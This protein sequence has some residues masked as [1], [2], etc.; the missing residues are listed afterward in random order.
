MGTVRCPLRLSGKH[1]PRG[2]ALELSRRRS[3]SG[4]AS[5]VVR[6]VVCPCH[7]VRRAQ[8]PSRQHQRRGMD[9]QQLGRRVAHHRDALWLAYAA[10]PAPSPPRFRDGLPLSEGQ[11]RGWQAA[12]PRR[13]RRLVGTVLRRRQAPPFAALRLHPRRSACGGRRHRARTRRVRARSRSPGGGADPG[14]DAGGDGDG[15]CHP[16]E[17][18]PAHAGFARAVPEQRR[19]A[20]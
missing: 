20:A 8:A 15:G 19:A 1:R 18:H 9:G 14:G 2:P 7:D 3:L 11:R 6:S 4:P 12:W 13:A 17:H 16:L 10:G 5:L